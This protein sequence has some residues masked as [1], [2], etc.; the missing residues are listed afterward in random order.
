MI[1]SM[2]RSITFTLSLA[3]VLV[4]AAGCGFEKKP[5]PA[6]VPPVASEQPPAVTQVSVPV[7]FADSQAQHLIPEERLVDQGSDAAVA[8]AIVEALLSGP[9][10]PTLHRALPAGIR[11]LEPVR[12]EGKTALVNLSKELAD[13]RGATGVGLALG[14]LRLSLT[15]LPAIELVQVLV[16]G[17]AEGMLDEGVPL[18][19]MDRPFYGDVI[20]LPDPNRVRVLQDRVS[21]G[22]EI[23]RLDSRKVLEFEGRMFGFT[24]EQLKAAEVTREGKAARARLAYNGT[25]FFIELAA[26][27]EVDVAPVWT[28]DSITSHQSDVGSVTMPVYFA[29]RNATNVI[30]EARQMPGDREAMV[31]AVVEA[32]L[33]G[34][35]DPNL[36]RVLPS[37]ARLIGPV[38]VAAGTATVNLSEAMRDLQSS[39]ESSLAIDA[40]VLSLTEV[41]AVEQVQILIEGQKGV[42]VG[43]Y[44]FDEPIGRGPVSTRYHLDMERVAWLQSRVDQG[45]ETWRLDA[46]QTL[47]WEGRA[48]GFTPD[49]LKT[50]QLEEQVD[51]ALARLTYQGKAYV[52]ELG[53]NPGE[54][55]IWYVKG[56]SLP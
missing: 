54:K 9:K 3:F 40:L 46:M 32:L 20:V 26:N 16:E 43:N 50:A 4:L 24:A 2:K 5:E 17:S 13:L 15:E 52:I 31:T 19:P 12:I 42:V 34:P 36:M 47:M 29:D 27:P 1:R 23:W 39:S 35:A 41:P 49:F 21:K 56:I 7:F 55:G 6:P 28:I 33:T 30:P 11:L 18:E 22:E 45:L 25:V 8:T 53:K 51:Q 44:K 37:G 48:F 38:Q 10:D 14:S